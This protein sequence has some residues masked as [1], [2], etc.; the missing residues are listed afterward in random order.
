[1]YI[2]AF[3]FF[4]TSAKGRIIKLFLLPSFRAKGVCYIIYIPDKYKFHCVASFI[5]LI[6]ININMEGVEYLNASREFHA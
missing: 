6:N 2:D 3:S 5:F 4:C 1:M